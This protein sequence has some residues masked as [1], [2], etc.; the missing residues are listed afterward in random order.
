MAKIN[1]FIIDHVIRGIM[2][3][4]DGTYMWSINQITNPSLNVSLTDTAQAVDA[5]G[6]PIAEFDRGRSAE[7]G[8]E[9]SIF[10]LGLYAAQMGNEVEEGSA[11]KKIV[12]PAFE[13]ITS[14]YITDGKYTLKHTPTVGTAP[15]AMYL[16]NGDG[17]LGKVYTVATAADADKFGYAFETN[18]TEITVPTGLTAD[19]VL[20]VMYE[21]EAESGTSVTADGVNFPKKGRFVM[22]V[23]GA[24]VCDQEKLIHAYVVF[25][26][27]KLD[28]NVDYSFTTDGTHP[29]TIK[30]LQDY[31]DSKKKLF[32]IIIPDEV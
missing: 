6:S 5:L 30:A 16:L 28:G 32:S 2:T 7:F 27:A 12:T 11:T 18:P 23:L 4:K 8:A 20:F 25:N 31:C 29:F 17:T 26:N 1:N 15:T 19:D 10:D 21:Y 3:K 14:E 22:E 9:N 24:D 13:E